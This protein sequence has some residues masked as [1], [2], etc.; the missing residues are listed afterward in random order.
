MD[1]LAKFPFE[2]CAMPARRIATWKCENENQFNI[3]SSSAEHCSFSLSLKCKLRQKRWRIDTNERETNLCT[4]QN[5]QR[6]SLPN[7]ESRMELVKVCTTKTKQ[8]VSRLL[9]SVLPL[10]AEDAGMFPTFAY[11]DI[12]RRDWMREA[13][14]QWRWLQLGPLRCIRGVQC[15]FRTTKMM[16]HADI[17]WW[18]PINLRDVNGGG[19]DRL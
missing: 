12:W 16:T 13:W 4:Y 6:K 11:F 8:T 1:S 14:N 7:G 18:S 10:E 9:V 15:L 19:K 3:H 2:T 5:K 17:S